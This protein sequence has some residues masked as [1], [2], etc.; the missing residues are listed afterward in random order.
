[1]SS[2][3][4]TKVDFGRLRA[5]LGPEVRINGG[6]TIMLLKDGSPDQIRRE[7][8]RICG[9]GVLAGGRFVLRDA[10]N[11]APC[12]PIENIEAMYEAG[13]TYGR[14]RQ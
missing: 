14:Y 1:M 5:E 3:L 4:T 10:N 2:F 13:K 9:S 6:P 12:T 11:L 7:V 8:R